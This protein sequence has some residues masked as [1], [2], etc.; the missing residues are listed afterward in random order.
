MAAFR[1]PFLIAK[2]HAATDLQGQED[3]AAI[4]PELNAWV[5]GLWFPFCVAM[6]WVICAAMTQVWNVLGM[7]IS[8]VFSVDGTR[9][10][11]QR[12][13][14]HVKGLSVA[15]RLLPLAMKAGKCSSERHCWEAT[16]SVAVF[17]LCVFVNSTL[18]REPE[19]RCSSTFCPGCVGLAEK[20][21]VVC[22]EREVNWG[23]DTPLGD[24]AADGS[25][26][27]AST[28]TEEPSNCGFNYSFL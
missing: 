18:W 19:G 3:L 4:Y 12:K 16:L 28:P 9:H 20:H 8:G 1:A 6:A 17:F 22:R 5:R 10:A 23:E 7:W 25:C 13:P 24:A 15:L 11:M 21:S 26:W 14:T 2:T 27:G